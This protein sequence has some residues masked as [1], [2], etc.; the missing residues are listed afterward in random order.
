MTFA[1]AVAGTRSGDIVDAKTALALL[2]AD[3]GTGAG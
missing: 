1:E 3:G 2:L